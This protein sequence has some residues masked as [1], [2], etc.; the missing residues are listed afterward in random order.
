MSLV[1]FYRQPLAYPC[2]TNIEWYGVNFPLL[3]DAAAGRGDQSSL[4]W[5]E[6]ETAMV[7]IGYQVPRHGGSAR[8]FEYRKEQ[9]SSGVQNVSR[10]AMVFHEPHCR[11]G[12][13]P[14][15]V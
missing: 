14:R 11:R 1:S 2:A 15:H 6:F 7:N 9:M 13:V 5:P 8:R 10:G 4:S 12:K 3:E